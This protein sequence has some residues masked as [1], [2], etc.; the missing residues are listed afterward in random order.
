MGQNSFSGKRV[1]VFGYGIEGQS[2]AEFFSD[3]R[4][5]VTVFDEKKSLNQPGISSGRNPFERFVGGIFKDIGTFDY[6]VVSPGIR[7]DRPVFRKAGKNGITF[8]TAT[9]VFMD[10]CPC[11]V[12]GVT[13]TKGKG[14]TSSLI[15]EMLKA[16]GIDAYLG[17]NIGTAPL[18]FLDKLTPLSVVVLELSSFQIMNMDRSPYMAVVLMV[19]SEHLD[20]H[21]DTD[22]YISAK[23]NLVRY[24]KPGD[25]A[26]INTDYQN[27]RKIGA[28]AKHS[29]WQVSTKTPVSR[30]SWVQDAL[31]YVSDGKQVESVVPV[32]EIYIPGRHNWENV[33]A[34]SAAAYARGVTIASIRT[35]VRTFRGLPHRLELVR[36]HMGI[37]YY[38]DSFSTTP[39]TAIAAINA[40]KQPKIVILGG[41]GKGSDFSELGEVIRT[42]G[43]I[44]AIIG[45]G[46]EWPKIK[47]EI[48]SDKFKIIEGCGSMKEIVD[49][50]LKIAQPN[51][52]VLLSPACASFD[53]FSNY[54]DRGDQF[55]QIVSGIP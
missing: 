25:I 9:N 45:I 13:G 17:G 14:T 48:P 12:I 21:T 19:T 6:L 33:T 40:F 31:V 49:A 24:Q 51:D 39:E 50:V 29:V 37:S 15:Y 52:V 18:S 46:A 36:T 7:L 8:T 54:K 43:S 23:S 41:S 1:A 47:P 22:E 10:L 34:A 32:S 38:D 26:V 11:P 5:Q 53:M 2:A 35:V 27:S 44:K 30:G 28:G 3:R 55:K 4:A 16:D 42:N 20:Y